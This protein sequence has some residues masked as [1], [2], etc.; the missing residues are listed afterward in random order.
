MKKVIL[1]LIFYSCFHIS[2][3]Q[4]YRRMLALKQYSPM[5]SYT[6]KK[7]VV[8]GSDT[9]TVHSLGIGISLANGEAD[10]SNFPLYMTWE[11]LAIPFIKVDFN[12]ANSIGKATF[13]N[14]K[15]GA[16]PIM[17]TAGVTAGKG[18]TL[19]VLPFGINATA[20]IATDF[21]DGYL[22]YGLAYDVFGCSFGITGMVNFTNSNASYYKSELG[23]ELRYI[24]G[25]N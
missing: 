10:N 13:F 14:P 11:Y 5:A 19:I 21:R 24:W 12:F 23:V 1:F 18:F 4:K 2:F 20:G 17:L 15:D 3:S 7:N 22:K 25:W 9:L 8:K 16:S 6:S